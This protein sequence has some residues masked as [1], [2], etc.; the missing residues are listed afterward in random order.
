[1]CIHDAINKSPVCKLHLLDQCWEMLLSTTQINQLQEKGGHLFTSKM[2]NSWQETFSFWG[3]DQATAQM[4]FQESTKELVVLD[5]Y[6][7]VD[8][9]KIESLSNYLD[10][11]FSIINIPESLLRSNIEKIIQSCGG[12]DDRQ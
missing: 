8:I 6:N 3:F 5:I 10:I 9:N 4:F 12:L 1:M 7:L 11:P 2:I